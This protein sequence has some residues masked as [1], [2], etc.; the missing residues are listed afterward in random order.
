MV[1]M[2][3]TNALS[4]NKTHSIEIIVPIEEDTIACD[5]VLFPESRLEKDSVIEIKPSKNTLK[6]LLL[7]KSLIISSKEDT[8]AKFSNDLGLS[9]Q[10]VLIIVDN[11]KHM[12]ENISLPF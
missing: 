4:G 7:N 3:A 10:A 6:P 8:N 5:V 12:L 9:F 11:P 1:T 2:A